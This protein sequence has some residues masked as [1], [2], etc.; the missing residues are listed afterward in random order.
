[1]GQCST[2]Y[3][4]VFSPFLG[5]TVIFF[6]LTSA[7]FGRVISSI[8]DLNILENLGLTYVCDL[9]YIVRNTHK[10]TVKVEFSFQLV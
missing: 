10:Y 5:L 8:P 4:P 9:C 7:I 2:D 6:G 3:L 1:M